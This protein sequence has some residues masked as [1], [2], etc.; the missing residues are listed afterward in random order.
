MAERRLI[1][2]MVTSEIGTRIWYADDY[3]HAREQ[4][5]DAFPEEPIVKITE[6]DRHEVF[7]NDDGFVPICDICFG[8]QRVEGDDWN[9][10]TGNHYSCE[11]NER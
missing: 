6:V 4:A 9:G 10:E 5:T 11:E 1:P 7:V 8:P 2:F 3:G